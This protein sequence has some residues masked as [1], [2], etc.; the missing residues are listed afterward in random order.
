MNMPNLYPLRALA[1]HHEI[2]FNIDGVVI[3]PKSD[4]NKQVPTKRTKDDLDHTD[5]PLAV[6]AI[7]EVS[8]SD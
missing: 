1:E 7:S 6:R 3:K 4:L 2:S 8:F 5:G